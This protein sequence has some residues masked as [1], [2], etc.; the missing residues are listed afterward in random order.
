[1]IYIWPKR[2]KRLLTF[3]IGKYGPVVAGNQ[4][5]RGYS[6]TGQKH[7][8]YKGNI[9]VFSEIPNVATFFDEI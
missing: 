4:L 6:K 9:L 3:L 7:G 5:D 1:M 8:L 2:K